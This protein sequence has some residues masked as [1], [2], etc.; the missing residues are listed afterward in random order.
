[1]KKLPKLPFNRSFIVGL[2]DPTKLWLLYAV[3]FMQ[4][5]CKYAGGVGKI[6][7][8]FSVGKKREGECS[9]CIFSGKSVGQNTKCALPFGLA[10]SLCF[11]S[12][13]AK[14]FSAVA[15]FEIAVTNIIV[16]VNNIIFA[17]AYI[18]FAVINF[19]TAVCNIGLAVIKFIDAV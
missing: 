6:Y 11:I 15:N 5:V 3:L 12:A 13:V 19:E 8:F 9:F 17:V 1:M 18:I 10:V 16:A 2:S 7:S 14:L 4:G